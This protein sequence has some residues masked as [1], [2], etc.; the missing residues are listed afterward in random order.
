MH[1]AQLTVLIKG[2]DYFGA[3]ILD[4]TKPASPLVLAGDE[5]EI[6]CEFYVL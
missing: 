3:S 6:F 5:R 2:A 1:I 4:Q